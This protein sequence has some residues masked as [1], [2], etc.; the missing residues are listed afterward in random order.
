MSPCNAGPRQ[1]SSAIVTDSAAAPASPARSALARLS[2]QLLEPQRVDGRVRQRVSVGR[3]DDRLL[4]E[5]SPKTSDVVLDGVARR[6][7][8]VVS[9]QRVDQRVDAD[10]ATA[11]KRKQREEALA[12]T[13]AH[14]RGPSTG[15]DLERPEQPD[16]ERVGHAGS[17]R[18]CTHQS[19]TVGR[20]PG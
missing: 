13:A 12:L 4:A 8:Q 20:A 11:A 16:F 6:G 15:E 7:R 17:G 3:G 19:R 5:C 2:E 14:V 1:S 18:A 9:P 10:D